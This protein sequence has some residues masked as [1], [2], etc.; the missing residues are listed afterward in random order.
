MAG[1]LEE[2]PQETIEKVY[3][4]VFRQVTTVEK[5]KVMKNQ[6]HSF[7]NLCVHRGSA[8]E[9]I[10]RLCCVFSGCIKNL[11]RQDVVDL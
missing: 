11:K 5:S 3:F 1:M 8:L 9:N 2:K 10:K 7:A 4:F 6:Y